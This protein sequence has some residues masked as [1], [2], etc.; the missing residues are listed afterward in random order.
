MPLIDLTGQ[1]FGRL[2]ALR[3]STLKTVA[4]KRWECVCDC[5]GTTVTTSL[6]LRSGHTTSCG[7][8]QREATALASRTHGHANRSRTYRTWKEMRQRCLNP[9]SDKYQWYGGRGIQICE[10]WA[11]FENFLA[12]MGERPIGKTIDRIDN[13]GHYELGNCRWATHK[14]QTRKQKAVKL[15]EGL[16]EQLRADRAA[17][18]TYRALG[19]KYG[20]SPTTASSCA[21]ARSWS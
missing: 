18:M 1:R 7:C 12:D 5:G 15:N 20:I 11:S 14:E 8:Y 13:D 19:R 10:R 2:I 9:K 21:N 4:G 3:P 16:V 6:K 17:G